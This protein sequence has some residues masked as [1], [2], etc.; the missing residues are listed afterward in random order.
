MQAVPH[1]ADKNPAKWFVRYSTPQLVIKQFKLGDFSTLS[2]K[3]KSEAIREWDNVNAMYRKSILKTLPFKATSFAEDK[4][5]AYDALEAGYKLAFDPSSVAYHYH[6]LS[7][8]YNFRVSY[9]VHYINYRFFNVT[10]SFQPVFIPTLRR[11]YTVWK[12]HQFSL[13]KK[14][15]WS[16][17]NISITLSS[18][19]SYLVFRA[20][21]LFSPGKWLDKSVSVFCKSIPQGKQKTT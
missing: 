18:L 10:D 4:L 7:F 15:S 11:L 14:I 6:H 1:D 21:I 8:V 12:Q 3:E 5:W 13:I 16:I 2:K 20:V 17:H 19:S 9:I